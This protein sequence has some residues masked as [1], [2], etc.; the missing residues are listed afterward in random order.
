[1][2]ETPTPQIPQRPNRPKA[3]ISA[4]VDTQD[5]SGRI[6]VIPLRPKRKSKE[7]ESELEIP[8]LQVGKESE[9]GDNHDIEPFAELHP[10]LDAEIAPIEPE[11]VV[12]A[13]VPPRPVRRSRTA[14]STDSGG[15]SGEKSELEASEPKLQ[16]VS[17]PSEEQTQT[18]LKGDSDVVLDTISGETEPEL[19]SLEDEDPNESVSKAG[20]L[21]TSAQSSAEPIVPKRPSRGQSRL[22]ST[23]NDAIKGNEPEAA[24]RAEIPKEKAGEAGVADTTVDEK[25]EASADLQ[26]EKEEQTENERKTDTLPVS[27]AVLDTNKEEDLAKPETTA[28][29]AN[30][31]EAQPESVEKEDDT[32]NALESLTILREKDSGSIDQD[33]EKDTAQEVEVVAADKE[34]ISVDVPES[35][36]EQTE[37]DSSE[38]S[39]ET[40]ET[41]ESKD[42]KEVK[43]DK[44]VEE[45]KDTQEETLPALEPSSTPLIPTRPAK[46]MPIV[47]KRPSKGSVVS[48]SESTDQSS[49]A[50][51]PAKSG[52]PKKA[53]PPKPKKLSSK[54]A[55]FQ[56][57]FNQPA[58]EAKPES[59]PSR[60]KGKLSSEKKNFAANLQNIMGRGIALPGMAN[61]EL[62][63]RMSET[64]KESEKTSEEK[65]SEENATE[66]KT[67]SLTPSIPRRARGPRGKRLPKSIQETTLKVE[68]PYK[69]T[70]H[71][72]WSISFTK[73]E[74]ESEV[75]E[76]TAAGEI[77]DR[78]V[79]KDTEETKSDSAKNS[80]ESVLETAEPREAFCEPAEQSSD[81]PSTFPDN[82]LEADYE[83]VTQVDEE[84]AASSPDIV[85]GKATELSEQENVRSIQEVEAA[86]EELRESADVLVKTG[87][88]LPEALLSAES[89]KP[90]DSV[91]NSEN[92]EISGF[93][94][95]PQTEETLQTEE[96]LETK[97]VESDSEAVDSDSEAVESSPQ[98][99]ESGLKDVEPEAKSDSGDV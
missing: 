45:D 68:S 73:Q 13:V 65:A 1:M 88:V 18:D 79:S 14:E 59:E 89:E 78:Y 6:P 46:H 40:K 86:I 37:R 21:V 49:G 17:Q 52:E 93:E 19:K 94:G 47:P 34:E 98:D 16:D 95:K 7:S 4:S 5:E 26:A 41:E 61:P 56:Q 54:I 57:M 67:E 62:M 35:T 64:E 71:D 31:L 75:F 58:P 2:S 72:V 97:A 82:D 77:I 24:T 99:G 32:K 90:V 36:E 48:S 10:Q 60:T 33:V 38:K 66:A 8:T 74:E 44:E 63:Q 84:T 9:I 39:E 43:D 51:P 23:E 28:E 27:D 80:T 96:I 69:V 55:A 81:I 70:V 29:E 25:K 91:K 92:E 85:N 53:P 42:T 11:Q 20:E 3:A 76:E 83:I 15:I 30:E 12:Q 50:I 87:D 22:P